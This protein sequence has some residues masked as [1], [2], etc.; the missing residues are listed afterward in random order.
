[1]HLWPSFFIIAVCKIRCYLREWLRFGWR[2]HMRIEKQTNY[3]SR[4]NFLKQSVAGGA[5]VLV[6]NELLSLEA[7]AEAKGSEA[8]KHSSASMM[9]VPFAARERVRLGIIGVG[10]R[11]SS[12]VQDLL[13]VENVEVK[14]ICDLVPEKVEHAQK[15]VT[16][17]GQP[18]PAGFSKGEW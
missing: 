13:A 15:A 4:R 2:R 9:E 10:G 1:M 14:A 3:I 5:G 16:D 7:G 11:G 17:A 8:K 12:L 6:A 18:R